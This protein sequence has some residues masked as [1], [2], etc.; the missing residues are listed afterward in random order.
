MYV[1]MHVCMHV[2]MYVSMYL[3]MYVS[4]YL[5]MYVYV[6]DLSPPVTLFF[7]STVHDHVIAGV[8][9]DRDAQRGRRSARPDYFWI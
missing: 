6:V 2:C 3:C 7:F 4:M 9:A 8:L 5:C 1:C